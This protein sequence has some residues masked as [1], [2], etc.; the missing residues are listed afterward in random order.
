MSLL[1]RDRY[2]AVLG[3]NGIGLC[4]R[5]GQENHWLG[6]VGLIGERYVDWSL[7]VDTL[8]HLLS[9]HAPQGAE[10]SVVLSAH[11]QRYCLIPWSE[12]I[13]SPK[14][15][16]A[17]AQACFEDIYGVSA[18]PWS[19]TLSPE[20]AG[21]S[22]IAA[23]LP[24]ELLLRLRTM[25]TQHGLRLRS[26]QPYLMTAFNRFQRQLRQ[27]DLLFVVAEPLRS[28][29]LLKRA[30]QW[31]AVHSTGCTDSDEALTALIARQCELQDNPDAP[32]LSVYLHAPGRLND[33]PDLIGVQLS[34]EAQVSAPVRDVLFTMSR[35]VA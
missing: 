27:G 13:N 26:V 35:A 18:Q 12:Q 11:Y 34:L 23:A 31:H 20:A 1:S 10:L 4:R 15:L 8:E 16:L 22:R 24:Q 14:E 29:L 6:S 33:L 19:V 9:E 7:A 5:R 17:Y 32:T 28:V 2:I 3:A 30:G 21:S 25:A